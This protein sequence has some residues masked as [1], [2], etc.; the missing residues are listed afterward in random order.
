MTE[1]YLFFYQSSLQIFVRLNLFL[2]RDDPIISVMSGQL[3]KFL[4]NLLGRFVTIQ[5]I[6]DAQADITRV[7]YKEKQ[8]PSKCQCCINYVILAS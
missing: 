6:I 4:K 3:Q 1:V 5:G 7:Q 8:L 2:Q